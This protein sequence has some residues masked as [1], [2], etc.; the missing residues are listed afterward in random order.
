[1]SR[2]RI[3]IALLAVAV[4]ICPLA[5]RGDDNASPSAPPPVETPVP[6]PGDAAVAVIADDYYKHEWQFTPTSATVTGVHDYDAQLD[7]VTPAAISAE[8]ARLHATLKKLQRLDS[9]ALSLNGQTDQQSL[10]SSIGGGLFSL[11]ERPAWRLSPSYYTDIAAGGIY[12]LMSRD[13]APL[14]RR[15]T[16]AVAREKQIPALL[17]QA[18]LNLTPAAIPPITATIDE[19]DAQGTA[20]FFAHDVPVAFAAVKDKVLQ[21]QLR[22]AN[23]AAIAAIKDYDAFLRASVVPKAHGS[24]AIGAA[25]YAR[26]ERLQNIVDIPLPHLLAVGEANLAKDRADFLATSRAIDAH[27]SPAQVLAVI[28]RDHPRNDQL[29]AAAQSDLNT[30]IAFIKAKHIIDLPPAPVAKVVKTPSFG[31]QTSFASMDSP[32]P[33]E[34]TAT[35][36]YYNVTL[37]DPHWTAQQIE[38]H[39]QFYNRFSRLVVSSHEA[40]PGHYTNYLFNKEHDLSLVRKIEWNVAFGEGWAHYDEQMMVDEGLGNGDPRY[41]LVQLQLA[42]W[43]DCRFV[44]GIKE[45]TQGMTV[46]QATKFFMDNAFEPR[47]PAYREAVRGTQDPLYGYYTLGKLMLLKLRADYQAK[48]GASYTLAGFHDALLSHGD[49][50]IY[51]LR[52]FLL[53]PDDNGALL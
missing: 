3:A 32:G 46:A 2:K 45:H 53:G 52:K 33:L 17:A 23:A 51:F 35:N 50:P 40:Y 31:A 10:E 4:C 9:G 18:K 27:K 16:L 11:E 24:Y 44:V 37:A 28:S 36:A 5:V 38:E 7:P 21:A 14:A 39:L 1:M 49:P 6:A 42:L 26:L 20:D 47:E 13:F 30:L 22:A 43:R 19:L 8:I 15:L 48:L 29:L 12:G 25:A 41:R 34:T